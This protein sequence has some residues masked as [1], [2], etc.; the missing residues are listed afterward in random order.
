MNE[1]EEKVSAKLLTHKPNFAKECN[2]YQRSNLNRILLY[3]T[4]LKRNN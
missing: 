4:V 1:N 2:F 3:F